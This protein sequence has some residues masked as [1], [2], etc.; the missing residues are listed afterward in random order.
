[1][2]QAGMNKLALQVRMN[3]YDVFDVPASWL[4]NIST[5]LLL[6]HIKGASRKADRLP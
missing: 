3:A 6:V 5:L 2:G 1:M 4:V